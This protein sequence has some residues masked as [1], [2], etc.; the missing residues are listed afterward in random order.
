[1]K[2]LKTNT[3][4]IIRIVRCDHLYQIISE[5][6]KIGCTSMFQI[7]SGSLGLNFYNKILNLVILL[8]FVFNNLE[9]NCWFLF[10]AGTLWSWWV[11]C[12]EEV[13]WI[14]KAED[15]QGYP[16]WYSVPGIS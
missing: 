4:E 6:F 10:I 11:R 16:L 13:Y 2:N 3:K 15:Y 9:S 8:Y 12:P 14:F 1:M 5:K 7:N